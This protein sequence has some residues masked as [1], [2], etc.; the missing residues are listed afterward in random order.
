M[1]P[2]TPPAAAETPT[3]HRTVRRYAEFPEGPRDPCGGVLLREHG[4]DGS[5]VWYCATCHGSAWFMFGG[6]PV[7]G[8]VA[9]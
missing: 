8:P 9:S 3:C 7:T 4:S 5:A 2:S 6:R 1:P